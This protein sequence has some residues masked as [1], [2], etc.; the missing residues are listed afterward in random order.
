MGR[1][2]KK[3]SDNEIIEAYKKENNVW[4]VADR[5][6]MCG[7]SVHERLIKLG[8][9]KKVN[10]FTEE[11]KRFLKENYKTYADNGDLK[12]LAAQLGRTKQFICRQ[13]KQLGLTDMK[14]LRPYAQKEGSNPYARNHARVRSLRGQPHKCEVC[15]IDNPE[16][17]YDWANLTGDYENPNDY[18][19][20][21]KPCHRK[22]DKGRV[23]RAHL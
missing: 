14:H 3:A 17:Q 16:K 18:K 20:M 23:M 19:R 22:Y 11:N 5:L 6:G 10:I 1:G 8:I 9:I 4:K 12:T 2:Q 15:G 13:A 7:Q 21:C